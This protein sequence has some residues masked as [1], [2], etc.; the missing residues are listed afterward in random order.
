[1]VLVN[2]SQRWKSKWFGSGYETIE[3]LWSELKLCKS[4]SSTQFKATCSDFAACILHAGG[5]A[6]DRHVLL[7]LR[8]CLRLHLHLH[9]SMTYMQNGCLILLFKL[10]LFCWF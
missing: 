8:P 5:P 4:F 1:M 7:A 10:P 9:A 6:V 3:D 2:V